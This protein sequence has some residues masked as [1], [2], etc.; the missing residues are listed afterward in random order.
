MGH[1]IE[2]QKRG[3]PHAHMCVW[4]EIFDPNPA[5]I[6][7]VIC[8]E[9]PPPDHPLHNQVK[10][11]MVHG[12]CGSIDDTKSCMKKG[13][14]KCYYNYPKPFTE[15]TLTE[16]QGYPNYRRR[17]IESGGYAT[18][19]KFRGMDIEINNQ[20]IVPYS[21]YLM[22]KYNCHI[23]VEYCASFQ[24]MKYLFKYQYKGHDLVGAGLQTQDNEEEAN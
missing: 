16:L 3:A 10:Q 12:P 21:P 24:T 23:N 17:S 11:F 20:N 6:D 8:A 13:N 1:S 22:K 5:N 9:L 14:G 4:I 7:N 2:F 18:T 19:K 15:E